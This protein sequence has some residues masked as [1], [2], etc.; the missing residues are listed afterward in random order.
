V[1]LPAEQFADFEK[2]FVA[3]TTSPNSGLA[4]DGIV[5]KIPS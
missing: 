3:V 4:T 1:D 2:Y 5:A